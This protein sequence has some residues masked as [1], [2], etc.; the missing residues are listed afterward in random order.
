MQD[1]CT[2]NRELAKFRLAEVLRIVL[3]MPSG[4]EKRIHV[5]LYLV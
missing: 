3:N 5:L 2:W 1:A 4:V